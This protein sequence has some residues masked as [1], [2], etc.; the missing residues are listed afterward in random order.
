M[1]FFRTKDDSNIQG[2]DGEINFNSHKRKGNV[3][4][5][6]HLFKNTLSFYNDDLTCKLIPKSEKD[7]FDRTDIYILKTQH[8]KII[9]QDPNNTC[10]FLVLDDDGN[11]IPTKMHD[12]TEDD[13]ILIYDNDLNDYDLSEVEKITIIDDSFSEIKDELSQYVI[14]SEKDGIIIND[15]I[16]F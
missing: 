14:Y 2:V 9:F 4:V 5:K 15:I 11:I 16:I 13:S 8:T 6:P 10:N 12:L 1:L 3:I 7:L